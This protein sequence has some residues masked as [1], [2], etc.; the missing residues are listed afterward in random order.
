MDYRD[1]ARAFSGIAKALATWTWNGQRQEVFLTVAGVN[2]AEV[3]GNLYDKLLESLQNAGIPGV[4]LK[5]ASYDP[6]FFQLSAKIQLYPD[7]LQETVS[8]NI[9]KRLREHYSFSAREFGRPVTSSE[10]ISIIQNIDGVHWLDLDELFTG[11]L[12]EK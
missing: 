3:K 7:F 1:Y 10:V 12:H 8:Q 9:E 2:G 4:P 6:V 5:V 11:T